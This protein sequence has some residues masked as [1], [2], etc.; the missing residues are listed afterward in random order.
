MTTGM[1]IYFGIGL[2]SSILSL[3]C[4]LIPIKPLLRRLPPEVSEWSST[5]TAIVCALDIFLWPAAAVGW[6]LLF[7]K[8]S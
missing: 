8:K 7:S 4:Y 5:H 2:A 1:W 3:C 6:A